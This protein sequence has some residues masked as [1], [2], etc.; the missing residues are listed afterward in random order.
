MSCIDYDVINL[1]RRHCVLIDCDV[2]VCIDYDV[3]VS[4]ILCF[5]YR[6]WRHCIMYK[7]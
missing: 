2:I 5:L 7:L 6:L 1:Y 4:Y 3:I